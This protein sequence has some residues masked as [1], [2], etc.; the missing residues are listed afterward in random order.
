ME[1]EIETIKGQTAKQLEETETIIEMEKQKLLKVECAEKVENES[2][3]RLS[4]FFA[5]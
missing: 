5:F 2:G 1:T 3:K 4:N